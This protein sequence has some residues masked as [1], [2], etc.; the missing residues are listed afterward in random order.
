MIVTVTVNPMAEHLFSVPHF[1]APGDFR[2]TEKARLIPTGKPLNVGRAL[3]DLGEQVLNVVALGGRTGRE[4]EELLE[5]ERLPTRVVSLRR[6]SRRGFTVFD[7]QG[8]TTTVYGPPPKLEDAEVEAIVAAVRSLMPIGKLVLGG[9]T[10]RLDLYP[11]L[12]ELGV[13]VVLDCR[14]PALID[15]LKASRDVILAKPNLKEVRATFGV[16]TAQEGLQALIDAGARSA[17]VTDE[18]RDAWFRVC[19]R[20]FRARPPAV[21]VVHS[22]GC[23]D[24]V[25]AGLLKKMGRP[26]RE[27]VAFAMACGAH[28]AGRADVA[29]L[30]LTDCEELA[31]EIEVQEV[32]G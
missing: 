28:A 22:V 20:T 15:S 18:G 9:S 12:C 2:A 4:I 24:A 25:A 21:D 3:H 10:S 27:M 1:E 17:V 6:E 26:A 14:G 8:R 7:E 13:P 23:G 5:K 31:R 11:R 16:H 32:S 30:N 29:S 19:G